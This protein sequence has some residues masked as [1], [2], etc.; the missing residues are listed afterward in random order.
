MI[1]YYMTT[2]SD[3]LLNGIEHANCKYVFLVVIYC[4]G[5]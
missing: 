4:K 2:A 5:M 3:F 1:M